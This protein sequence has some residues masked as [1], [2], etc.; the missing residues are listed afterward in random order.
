MRSTVNA[1]W[2]SRQ[3]SSSPASSSGFRPA[4]PLSDCVRAF[5]AWYRDYYGA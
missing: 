5:V 2:T 4:V 3:K 1:C